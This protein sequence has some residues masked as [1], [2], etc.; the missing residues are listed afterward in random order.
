LTAQLFVVTT[1]KS[2][3]IKARSFFQPLNV[4]TIAVQVSRDLCEYEIV[5]H[6][7][8]STTLDENWNTTPTM[9]DLLV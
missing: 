1:F 8:T 5:R 9:R 6:E 4:L 2:S 7:Y 3:G